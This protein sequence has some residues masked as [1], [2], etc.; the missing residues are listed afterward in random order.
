M[1]RRKKCVDHKWERSDKKKVDWYCTECGEEFP[2]QEP[3]GHLDCEVAR[4][5]PPKCA[6][7][8]KRITGN[9]RHYRALRGGKLQLVHEACCPEP[10]L[11]VIL[12]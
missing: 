8:G 3:C 10:D 6:D 2:C 5:K 1:S 7:C 12:A 9:V 11:E 4:G